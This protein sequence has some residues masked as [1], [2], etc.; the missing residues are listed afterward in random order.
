MNKPFQQVNRR[1]KEQKKE[2]KKKQQTKMIKI[3]K[4]NFQR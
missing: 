3:E 2:S 4:C 1:D